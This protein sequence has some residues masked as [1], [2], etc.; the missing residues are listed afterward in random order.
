MISSRRVRDGHPCHAP[1]SAAM[2]RSNTVGQLSRNVYGSSQWRCLAIAKVDCS[3]TASWWQAAGER[4]RRSTPPPKRCSA[5]RPTRPP[6]TWALAIGAARTRVRRHRLVDQRR[7]AGARA[8]VSCS[9]RCATTREELRELAIAEV[10]APR[11][12]TSM[13]QLDGPGRGSE[14]LRGHRGGLPVDHRPR[15]RGADGH[16]DPPHDRAGRPSASSAPS[17]RGTSRTRSTSPSSGPRWRRATRW[18]SSR[19]PTPLGAQRFSAS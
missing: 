7:A 8:S 3:S 16:Q 17:R 10:G 6:T 15:H 2:V 19:R 5:S 9:R 14:L 4:S 18:C 12:L 13:A 1:A 11:M